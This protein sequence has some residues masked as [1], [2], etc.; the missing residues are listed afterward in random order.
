MIKKVAVLQSNYLP[1]RGYFDIIHDVDLF[2]F[3]DE[4][5]FT[6]NDWRNRNKIYSKQGL[7]WL[8]LPCGSDENRKINEVLLPGNMPWAKQQW[9]KI[10]NA[11]MHAPFF[12]MYKD[13][14]YDCYFYKTWKYL[15]QLNQYLIKHISCN[16]LGIKTEFANSIDF[17]SEGIKHK[18]LL[19]LVKSTK[20]TTYV[21]G[22]AAKEYI[23]EEDYKKEGIEIVWK[24]YSGYPEH[25]Q[26][27]S[28]F[29]PNVSIIDLLF[30]VGPESPYYIW[31]W[32]F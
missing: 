31:G 19:S 1:W 2:I 20:C 9:D 4:V 16:L 30:N 24:D 8:S 18:K 12:E 26:Q 27:N 10:T 17:E 23:I 11:Y 7:S 21:S 25:T 5:Q 6:K 28:P 22:P 32:R 14:F 29:E 13:F 15:S 3:Y